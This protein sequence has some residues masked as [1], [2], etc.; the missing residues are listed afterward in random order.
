[1]KQPS[2]CRQSGDFCAS[3]TTENKRDPLSLASACVRRGMDIRHD[4][5]GPDSHTSNLPTVQGS[6]HSQAI[7]ARSK[8]QQG[9]CAPIRTDGLPVHSI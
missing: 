8:S 2:T 6:A 5:L 4:I 1:M 3:E 9:G 7:R